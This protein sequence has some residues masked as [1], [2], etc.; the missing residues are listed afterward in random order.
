MDRKNWI[1]NQFTTP[2]ID[3]EEFPD[4]ELYMDQVTTFMERHLAGN[5]RYEEDKI[6]TKT[7]INNYTKNRLLPPPKKKKYSKDHIIML[8]FIYYMKNILNLSDIQS[9]LTPLA[10]SFFPDQTTEQTSK[11]EGLSLKEIYATVMESLEDQE[12]NLRDQI[13]EMYQNSSDIFTDTNLSQE[14]LDYL[15]DFSFICQLANDIHVKKQL[16][17]RFI[18]QRT[19]ENSPEEF[20]NKKKKSK[21]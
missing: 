2:H 6:L 8:I 18:D 20:N 16:L 19:K 21:K 9:I 4:I 5:K 10:D 7:M 1:R 3:A 12:D 17:E 11:S 15:H 13:F 14:D